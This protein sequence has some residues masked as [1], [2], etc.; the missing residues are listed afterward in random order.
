MDKVL[1][2]LIGVCAMV[3]SDDI[4]VYSINVEEHAKHL[5]LV[6]DRLRKA[7]LR[8]KPTKCTCG[9]EQIRLLGYIVNKDEIT[10]DPEKTEAIQKLRE[11]TTLK[12][13]RSFLGMTGY[14]RQCIPDY[15]H[16]AEPLEKLKRKHIRFDWGE[17]QRTA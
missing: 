10:M 12:E 4:V 13:V 16:V 9:L 14:Y 8:L 6:F 3:D 5:E 1:S 2:D 17:P 15:A 7:G 11:P